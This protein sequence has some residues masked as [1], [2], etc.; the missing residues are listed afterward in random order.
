M[1][2]GCY[3][4]QAHNIL[5]GGHRGSLNEED[6]RRQRDYHFGTKNREIELEY[7]RVIYVSKHPATAAIYPGVGW[8]GS[9]KLG[10]KFTRCDTGPCF[11]VLEGQF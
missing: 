4:F 2:H 6:Q 3:P 9:H 8:S 5:I 7:Q 10:E 1:Y 11:C